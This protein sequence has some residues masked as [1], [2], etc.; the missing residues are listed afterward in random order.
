MTFSRLSLGNRLWLTIALVVLPVL[1]LSIYDYRV[2]RQGALASV[3]REAKL[4]VQSAH[5]E[6]AAALRHIGQVLRIMAASDN[7]RQLDPDE[8]NGLATRVAS[9]SKDI[10]VVGASRPDGTVF[11]SSIRSSTV[12]TV[13][14]RRWFQEALVSNDMTQG[15]FTIGKLSGQPG[16]TFGLPLR[17]DTGALRAALFVS[18]NIGWFDRLTA[19]YHL[20]EGWTSV[21]FTDDINVI[22]RHPNPDEWRGKQFTEESKARLMAALRDKRD[23]L[24]IEGLDGQ[25]R[26]FVL[27]PLKLAG[28]QLIVSVAGP[29]DITLAPIDQAF[30]RRFWL[31]V[32]LTL[33]P[34]FL[35][36]VYLYRLIEGWVGT[37][38]KST[39]AV[40]QGDLKTRIS[41]ENL[42]SELAT[43]NHRFNEMATALQTRDTAHTADILAIERLNIEL[44][45]HRQ[46]LEALVEQRTHELL[47]AKAGAEAANRAKSEFL[48][49]MSHEIRTP[50]NAITGFAYLLG[51]GALNEDQRDKLGK[52]TRA[53][54]HLLKIINDILDLAKIESGKLV[55][56]S[57]RFSPAEVINTV[58]AMV[59]VNAARN[60]V[61]LEVF[62]DDLPAYVLGD[63]T[64]LRQALLNFAGNAVKF[65][66]QGH[67]SLRGET[68]TREANVVVLKF[69]VTDTG[70]GIPA[71]ALPRMFQPFEQIDAST[72]RRHGGTGLGLSI[73]RHLAAMMGGEAGV[74]SVWGQGSTF[75]LTARFEAAPASAAND[76]DPTASLANALA[77]LRQRQPAARVLLVEDDEMNREVGNE[78]LDAAGISV[79]FAEDGRQ[80]IEQASSQHYDLILMDL[81]MPVMGGI[82]ATGQLRTLANYHETPILALT[83]DAFAE[84][85]SV[86]LAAGMNDFITKPIDPEQFYSALL[87]WLPQAHSAP[88]A[89][90]APPDTVADNATPA[91]SAEALAADMVILHNL[92]QAGNAAA[93]AFFQKLRPALSQAGLGNILPLQLAIAAYDYTQAAEHLAKLM[94]AGET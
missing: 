79:D 82:E 65:T 19:N 9:S 40:A 27:A 30:W 36:R 64:R 28:E 5:I 89:P 59:Q 67:I 44:K 1:A 84:E 46:H 53:T 49:N 4:M 54:Q 43:L 17:D 83:A 92:L 25:Q 24:V 78:M 88:E 62:C 21:L 85:R 32:V 61:A 93:S 75:W 13:N 76:T 68:L 12:I 81:Q 94:A 58:S 56:E 39:R 22:S 20:P 86:C 48:A 42:P 45:D 29:V 74:E 47:L 73:S 91:H 66:K 34:A 33:I 14:D 26:L 57:R 60:G 3:R 77:A 87:R 16:I 71:A 38:D 10:T 8:C 52:I 70:I 37:M 80:A 2:D 63:E 72:T 23:S 35:A 55:L 7:M 31:L 51:S 11:C 15:Q 50:M 41:T 6:E 90:P 18:S 69:S